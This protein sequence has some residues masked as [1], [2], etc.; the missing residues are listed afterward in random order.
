MREVYLKIML[1]YG[2]ALVTR[3][4]ESTAQHLLLE[5]N[6]TT[7]PDRS[8]TSNDFPPSAEPFEWAVKHSQIVAVHTAVIPPAQQAAPTSILNATSGFRN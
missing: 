8:Y 5:Y 4:R 3:V 7:S 6:R 2:H 1:E